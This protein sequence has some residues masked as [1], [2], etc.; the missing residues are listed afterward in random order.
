[1]PSL[2]SR[3][4]QVENRILA[5][6]PRKQYRSLFSKLQPVSL[7][8]SHIVFE[9]NQLIRFI[10]F[11]V[12]AMIA[13]ISMGE[14]G[15]KGVEVFTVGNEGVVGVSIFLNGDLALNRAIVQLP[16]TALR[17]EAQAFRDILSQRGLLNSILE[18]YVQVQLTSLSRSAFCN[19][20][21]KVEGRLARWLL[22]THDRAQS[23]TFSMTQEF[24][25]GL[26][27]L[28]RPAVS[29]AA[30]A[31]QGAGLISYSHGKINVLDREGLE[32]A[33]CECYR[34]VGRAYDH[35]L[36]DLLPDERSEEP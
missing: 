17:I 14:D 31:L 32:A 30:N 9:Q 12:T 27:G 19:C 24:A 23:D 4:S 8:L 36:G 11:P 16:G 10:Y 18:L 1:M 3:Q 35:L 20:F 34:I 13:L 5:A 33:A 21:H 29:I 25:A 22:L 2:K 26:L 6:L 15:K 7:P 28:H